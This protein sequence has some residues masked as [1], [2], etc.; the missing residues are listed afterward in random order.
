MVRAL[1]VVLLVALGACAAKE[2][3]PGPPPPRVGAPDPSL[4]APMARTCARLAA[5][6]HGH[7]NPVLRDPGACVEHW[8]S[9]G[10]ERAP[11]YRCLSEASS[12]E[13]VRACLSGAGDARAAEFCERRAGAVSGCDGDRLVSCGDDDILESTVV[14][15]AAMGASCRE[16]RAAGG[17]VLRACFSPSACP[18]G[19]PAARCD[20]PTTVLT[21]ADGAVDR[22][23]CP[24]GTRCEEHRDETGEATA[25]CQ[26]PGQRRCDALGSRRCDGDRLVECQRSGASGRLRVTDCASLGLLCAATGPRAGCYVPSR[27]ECDKEMLPRCEGGGAEVVFCAA[28]RVARIACTAIGMGRCEPAGRGTIAACSPPDAEPK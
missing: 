9:E 10:A 16:V 4:L 3:P 24:V 21:C 5:C 19:A 22:V 18:P 15:C 13:R 27:V 8:L 25:T 26:L 2:T 12:C 11:L 20:G 1:V 14:D 17:L 7:D 6:A 23:T 28:G